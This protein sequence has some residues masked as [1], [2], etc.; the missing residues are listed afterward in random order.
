M[1]RILAPLILSAAVATLA[2][3]CG[4][5][6]PH[7]PP[8]ATPPSASAVN[9]LADLPQDLSLPPGQ[10]NFWDLD[11]GFA[12]SDGGD[13][14]FDRAVQL[15]LGLPNPVP[16]ANSLAGDLGPD[17]TPFPFDQA[18]A[19][20]SFTTPVVT[21]GA[22]RLAAV[23]P[24]VPASLG[25][26]LVLAGSHG[27]PAADGGPLGTRLSQA[28]DLPAAS[29]NM[30]LGWTHHGV[31]L[32]GTIPGAAPSWRVAVRDTASGNELVAFTSGVGNPGPVV[33]LDVSAFAG[34]RVELLF[35]LV[36]SPRGYMAIDDVS[37]MS[38]GNQLV[39][40]G[41]FEEATLA[42]W[43]VT[44]P[45]QPCQVVSGKRDV[46]GLQVERRVLARPEARWA[47]FVDRFTN[48]GT[49][50]VTTEANYL[51]E[52][53][54]GLE[55]VIQRSGN[56]K[57]LSSWD[58]NGVHPAR[59]DLAIVYGA[60]ALP[61]AFRSSTASLLADGSPYVWTRFPLSVAPGQ[62]RVVVHFVVLAESRTGDTAWDAT[63]RSALADRE[64][65]AI[66]NGFWSSA[67]YR[68]GMTAEDQAG[69]VNF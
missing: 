41:S 53:G 20:L 9:A 1:R 11:R 2:A 7:A 14:Q 58:G 19:E 67:A 36:G 63:T 26:E 5:P 40:N 23:V 42:P 8:P 69:L 55:A 52:L 3:G 50:T 6:A 47:R 32:D 59:R 48:L 24:L 68:E 61:T 25:H 4:S 16:S 45:D 10:R 54:A 28:I 22:G 31:V 17:L 49:T 44:G 34:R 30:L 38:G 13:D 51:H 43:T 33:P 56:Q 46:K 27:V 35:D 37:I 39:V 21:R 66:V 12:L 29:G 65:A 62:T 18:L 60:S 57:S 15:H 64:A